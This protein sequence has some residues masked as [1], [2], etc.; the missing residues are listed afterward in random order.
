MREREREKRER[1][2]ERIQCQYSSVELKKIYLYIHNALHT[3]FK[4]K[5]TNVKIIK[6]NLLFQF[7]NSSISQ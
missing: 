3:N 4:S 2:H 6:K 5:L 7:S 1:E